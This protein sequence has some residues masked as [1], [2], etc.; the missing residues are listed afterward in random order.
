MGHVHNAFP[1]FDDT[2]PEID[3]FEDMSYQH[4][5]A[6]KL[7]DQTRR[8]ELFVDYK[9]PHKS[10]NAEYRLNGEMHRYR[11]NKIDEEGNPLDDGA[12]STDDFNDVLEAIAAHDAE[13]T[14]KANPG[15]NGPRL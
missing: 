7:L 3:G 9:D 6:P 8:L 11:M 10:E 14:S 12:I 5:S 13:A 1:D 4:D 15:T 2:L